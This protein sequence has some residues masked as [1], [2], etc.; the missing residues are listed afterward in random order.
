MK[1]QT[2]VLVLQDGTVYSG[3]AF[4]H[5]GEAH[6]EVCFNTGMTGYQEVLTDPS[7]C[8]QIVT[9]TCPHIGNYGVNPDDVE[10]DRIQ[11]AGFIVREGCDIPS[12][13]RATQSL[14]SYLEEQG[15][16]GIQD[17]DTRA[18]TRKLR[19]EGAM[20]G[21]I[22]S[23]GRPLEELLADVR[24]LPSMT[25]RDLAREVSCEHAWQWEA[26]PDT[27]FKVAALDFG[28]KRNSLRL[29]SAHRCDITV[30]PAD[31][32]AG[33]LLASAPDGVFLSNGP[34]DPDAVT[35]GIETVR[36]L[37]GKLPLFGICLGHQLLAL[38]LGARTY[39][40]KFGHRGSN[41]PVKNLLTGSVEITSQNH[42]FAVDPESLPAGT[43]IT[44]WNLNDETLEGFRCTDIPAFSVQYHPEAAPGP[45]D[46]RYLFR[47]F[48]DLMEQSR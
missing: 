4:G 28:V 46:S 15:I 17:I 21:V 38:A 27:R 7:Y 36:E 18:L 20:N 35:Y 34:G 25:G 39:K 12:S 32:T 2:A 40:L 6:G 16:V 1:T 30:F 13:Y 22:C 9:M 31:T 41:H 47:Q 3:T 45:H 44:H 26:L 43:E 24:G 48:T 19:T 33:E 5:I 37:L 11:V 14:P 42:G 23:T 8:G 10:S 29:L